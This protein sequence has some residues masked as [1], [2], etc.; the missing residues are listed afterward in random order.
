MDAGQNYIL[1]FIIP[2]KTFFDKSPSVCISYKIAKGFL[3]KYSSFLLGDKIVP[4]EA[5]PRGRNI[6][7]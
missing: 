6:S 3:F 4:S 5:I 7:C 2:K 1:T